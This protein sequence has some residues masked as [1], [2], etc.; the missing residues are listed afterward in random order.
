MVVVYIISGLMAVL[1]IVV[2][3]GKGDRLIA[4]YNTASAEERARYNVRRLR[5]LIGLL[6]L[7]LAPLC[8][9]LTRESAQST[10]WFFTSVVILVVLVLILANTWAKKRP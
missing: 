2:L 9:L 6:M 4:G 5:L 10:G 8:L 3:A 7:I 1:G